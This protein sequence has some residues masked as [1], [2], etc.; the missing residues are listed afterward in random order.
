MHR[1]RR[2]VGDAGCELPARQGRSHKGCKA[3]RDKAIDHCQQ[4]VVDVKVGVPTER[5]LVFLVR[6]GWELQCRYLGVPVPATALP[7]INDRAEFQNSKM[8]MVRGA[9][10]VVATLAV[11]VAAPAYGLYRII[12]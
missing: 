12:S 2:R 9:Y 8:K 1:A 4:H 6:D 10:V 3:H 5:L 7:N 11:L